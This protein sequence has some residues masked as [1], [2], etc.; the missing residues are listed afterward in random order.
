MLKLVKPVAAAGL[1]A[2]T[3]D[4]GA[5]ILSLTPDSQTVQVND[6]VT[7]NVIYD[8]QGENPG[9][10]V[11][12]LTFENSAFRLEKV[13]FD[14][15]LPDDPGFRV[16]P[17]LPVTD[18]T[19]NLGFGN[20]NG[21]QGSGKAISLVFQALTPGSFEFLL[22]NP[23]PPHDPF[24]KVTGTVTYNSATVEVQAVPIPA[25][26]GLFASGLAILGFKSRRNP[27]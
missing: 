12:A 26:I 18:K 13:E 11:F 22:G 3:L 23:L 4:G 6:A 25:G 21:I 2:W 16:S 8:T 20:A 5:V 17:S 15:N 14:D 9:G 7:L 1:M 19:F 24:N 10:G 27:D